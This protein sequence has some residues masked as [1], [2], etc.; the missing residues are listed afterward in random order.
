MAHHHRQPSPW[1]I[2]D[3]HHLPP[4]DER[5]REIARARFYRIIDYFKAAKDS[6]EQDSYS[7][8]L[9]IKY[10][11]EYA[12]SEISKDNFLRVFFDAL[13]ISLDNSVSI[14]Y[15]E[16]RGNFNRFAMH[17]MDDFFLPLRATASK[18][19][20]PTPDQLSYIRRACFT[21]DGHRCVVSR[22]F[23]MHE[24]EVRGEQY[25]MRTAC[26]DDGMTLFDDSDNKFELLELAHIVPS[27]LTETEKGRLGAR[28]R[29]T[30]RILNMLDNGVVDLI[31]GAEI[32]RPR[33]SIV[34]SHNIHSYF[35]EF[36]VFFDEVPSQ[37]P[38]TYTIRTFRPFLALALGLPVTRTLF[39]FDGVDPPS[40][41]LLALHRAIAHILHF[42]GAGAYIS[43][44]SHDMEKNVAIQPDGSTNLAE[45]INLRL[46]AWHDGTVLS[47]AT[48]MTPM[49]LQ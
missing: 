16:I 26:D 18:T 42:S 34:L 1:G 35:C 21:R 36:G 44:L 43:R 15:L 3:V 9:L 31:E 37:G 49:I 24:A 8:S 2:L 41:R 5:L 46:G 4:L 27:T 23:D 11:F 40:P 25:G 13:E 48:P 22:A 29:S 39:N 33:N 17:L 45:M 6:S 28:R 30:L 7:R 12:R 32:G 38:H 47:S 14:P 20:Q 10:T 19:L